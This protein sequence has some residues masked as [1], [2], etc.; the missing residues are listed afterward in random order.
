MSILGIRDSGTKIVVNGL[1]IWWDAS[2]LISYPTTGNNII[3]IS[4]NSETGGLLN[5]TSFN[6]T[7]G[8]TLVFDGTNDVVTGSSTNNNIFTPTTGFTVGSWVYP[9]FTAADFEGQFGA[10]AAGRAAITGNGDLTF[11]LSVSWGSF[12]MGAIR[13]IA[14]VYDQVNSF[15]FIGTTDRWTNNAWNYIVAGHLNNSVKIWVNGSLI[16]TITGIQ[17]AYRNYTTHKYLLSH[18]GTNSFYRFKGK[19]GATFAYNR[20]L[21]DTEV[22]QNFNAT[23]TRFNI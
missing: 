17:S 18:V 2:Q 11:T 9:E 7:N 12:G 19:I 5:G 6:S 21:S 14:Y 8:G 3:D 10:I 23:R 13:G 4:G 1:K 16:G 22:L 20:L 15:G